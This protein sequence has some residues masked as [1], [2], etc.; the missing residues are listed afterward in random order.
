MTIAPCSWAS[1]A[2][3]ARSADSVN[4]LTAKFGIVHGRAVGIML[5]H[6]VRY[7]A[8]VGD[9]PYADLGGGEEIAGCIEGFLAAAGFPATLS[10]CGVPVGALPE[11]ALEA[12]KQWTATFN[13]VP[14]RESELLEIYRSAF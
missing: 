3:A 13:P 6:V 4:P 2:T 8:S 9:N 10:A 7:N 12:A 5:P 11:L 1:R 14:V